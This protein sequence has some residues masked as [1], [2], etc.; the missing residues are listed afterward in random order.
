M[1]TLERELE[2]AAKATSPVVTLLALCKAWKLSPSSRLAR[3]ARGFGR[4]QQSDGVPGANQEEREAAWLALAEHAGAAELQ[5]LLA[6]PWSKRPKDAARRLTALA[7]LGPD[8]RIVG[9]LL[10][11]DTG[12]RYASAAG[13]RFW[14]DVYELLLS[15]GSVEA[16]DRVPKDLPA[17]EHTSPWAAARYAAIFEPLALRWAGKWP[18]EPQ[19]TTS[20]EALLS[21]LE[22]KLAPAQ[23]LSAGLLA[24]VHASPR[25]D[26]PRLVFADALTEQG[27]ARG[28]FIALQFAHAAGELPMGKREHMQRLLAASGR[29][30]FDGVESQVSPLAV[31]RKGFLSEVR[32][33]TRTPTPNSPGWTTVECL[34]VGGIA[35]TL[36]TF[37]SHPHLVSVHT[38]RT[39]RGGTLEELARHGPPI[40]FQLI[41]VSHLGGRDMATPD[42]TLDTLRLL[43][44]IDEAVWW[45]VGTP[46]RQHLKTL[47]LQA[48]GAFERVGPAVLELEVADSALQVIEVSVRAPPWPLPWIGDWDLRFERDSK[49]KFS[50]LVVSIAD[51]LYTG[52]E[53]ALARLDRD[54]LKSVRVTTTI[55]RGPTW[56]EETRVFL[57]SVLRSQRRLSSVVF[58]LDKPTAL[59][60]RAVV[61]EGR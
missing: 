60:P 45:F 1:S 55:R 21:A 39:F 16:A 56:R 54:Q 18:V 29:S 35:T 8:P 43:S 30:W 46:L 14:Q 15:W 42:W 19:L 53:A 17:S 34:D 12:N 47:S 50:R 48:Q 52:L 57:E 9:S 6:T 51:E 7:R 5:E 32:L 38:L 11:L 44:P 36:S 10:E 59:P 22:Q 61:H 23:Q 20:V 49:G 26:S 4:Q 13:H 58:E 37:L 31:F 24:A 27:D 40:S 28:E 3:L 2:T 33:A 25:E 41:E